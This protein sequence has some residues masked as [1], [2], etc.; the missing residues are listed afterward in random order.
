MPCCGVHYLC[1]FAALFLILS[2]F[3]STNLS[4]NLGHT[5]PFPPPMEG[6]GPRKGQQVAISQL[7]RP[8]AADQ[9]TKV[10]YQ[11]PLAP[12]PPYHKI[13]FKKNP[14]CD[15]GML[16]PLSGEGTL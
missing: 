8:P 14:L 3:S 11:P 15:P 5:P 10:S 6:K 1:L 2:L 4:H 9:S 7:V 12:K 13:G 16:F